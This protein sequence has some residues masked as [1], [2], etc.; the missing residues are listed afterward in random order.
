MEGTCL[1]KAIPRDREFC[2]SS[3]RYGRLLKG[4]GLQSKSLADSELSDPSGRRK[5]LWTSQGPRP[6]NSGKDICQQGVCCAGMWP[7]KPPGQLRLRQGLF[8]G[9]RGHTAACS[10][11]HTMGPWTLVGICASNWNSWCVFLFV[12]LLTNTSSWFA[13]S[14][15]N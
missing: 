10:L 4:H 6:L 9:I 2:F 14:L 8:P 13:F 7:D 12:V 1:K 15:E 5:D 3:L 11:W